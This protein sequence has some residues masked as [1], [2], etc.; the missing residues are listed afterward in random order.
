MHIFQASHGFITKHK[1]AKEIRAFVNLEAAGAGG[2][3]LLFQAGSVIRIL[4]IYIFLALSR[5]V[6]PIEVRAWLK[7]LN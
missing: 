7:L 2:R 4:Y 3:E 1:W 6:L 5:L